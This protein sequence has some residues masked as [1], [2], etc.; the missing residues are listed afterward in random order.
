MFRSPESRYLLRG[1]VAGIIAVSTLAG[2]IWIDNPY[3]QLVTAGI[4]A[5]ALYLG[6]GQVS[7]S[8]EP[9]VGLVTKDDAQVP[10]TADK[11]PHQP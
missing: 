4:S 8:V 7:G 6:I 10:A 1:L 3:V 5:A 11:P 2:T 9:F